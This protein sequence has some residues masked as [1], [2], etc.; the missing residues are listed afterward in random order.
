MCLRWNYGARQQI[1]LVLPA[2][3]ER[4]MRLD[5]KDG[6]VQ[7]H[8]DLLAILSLTAVM[9]LVGFGIFS[10]GESIHVP[11]QPRIFAG[12]VSTI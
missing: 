4:P 9:F 7:R 1:G 5:I 10:L 6:Y 11:A 3:E 12:P 8:S 2:E